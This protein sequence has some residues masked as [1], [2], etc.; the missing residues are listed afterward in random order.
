VKNRHLFMDC[1]KRTLEVYQHGTF[2]RWQT[3]AFM[4]TCID[5]AMRSDPADDKT[6]PEIRDAAA[7]P[8][9]EL[10]MPLSAEDQ[11]FQELYNEATTFWAE[12]FGRLRLVK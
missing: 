8:K 6:S 3:V 12:G 10:S 2:D 11:I 7:V 1:L 9:L 4:A 5:V